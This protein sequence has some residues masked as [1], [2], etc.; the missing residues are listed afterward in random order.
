ME[1]PVRPARL[2]D[3]AMLPALEASAGNLFRTVPGLEWIADDE[4]L[5]E[6][7][8]RRLIAQGTV[9]VAQ[10]AGGPL[11]GFLS[12]EVFGDEL[13]IWELAVDAGSQQ[14][15][16]GKKLVQKACAHALGS[17]L[18][19]VTLTTF[20]D[21]PW[22]APWYARLGFRQEPA[23]PGSRLAGVLEAEARHGLP[24]ERR[25]ALRLPVA[26]M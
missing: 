24:A 4:V 23:W 5:P 9:W 15:G 1:M 20:R 11:R 26:R 2:E 6:A 16:I 18:S 25:V 8:H 22:N 7:A 10:A 13:H 12:A 21:V 3:A 17:G 14:M 19:A